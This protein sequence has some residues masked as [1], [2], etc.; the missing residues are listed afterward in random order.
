MHES[1]LMYRHLIFYLL[2]NYKE[3][4]TKSIQSKRVTHGVGRKLSEGVITH[5]QGPILSIVQITKVCK[6]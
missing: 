5:V 2:K 4:L 3:I 1:S 6:N